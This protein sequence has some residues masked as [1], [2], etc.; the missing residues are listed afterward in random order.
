MRLRQT[1]NIGIDMIMM[2]KAIRKDSEPTSNGNFGNIS[3]N[4]KKQNTRKKE[5]KKA[6]YMAA[7]ISIV[8]MSM[9]QFSGINLI[10]LYS[11]N[12][13]K[14]A[15]FD[16]PTSVWI[17]TIIVYCANSGAVLIAALLIDKLG[18]KILMYISS[19]GMICASILISI[20][21]TFQ[22]TNE[23][24]EIW[25]YLV[26][27]SMFI[28]VV[29][30]E[31][32]LGPIPW[33]FSAEISPSSHR[34][35]ITGLNTFVNQAAGWFIAYFGETIGDTPAKYTPFIAVLLAGTLFL[36]LYVPETKGKEER[37]I[38]KEMETIKLC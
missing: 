20:A 36:K 7:L 30:F 9:Q 17:G 13:L 4:A 15:G 12:T 8:L 6:I 37:Q 26:L 28:T 5:S 21:L 38:L 2:Q 3:I 34:G 10:F 32:G 27:V 14:N 16:N 35:M 19:F 24:S 25:G 18:R 23:S 33:L 29:T 22:E 31:M 11:T 1:D